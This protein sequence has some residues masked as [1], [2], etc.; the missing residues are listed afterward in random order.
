MSDHVATQE[1]GFLIPHPFI[2]SLPK[3]PISVSQ[4]PSTGSHISNTKCPVPHLIWAYN[5]MFL[6][7]TTQS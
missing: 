5:N 1:P 4:G 2:L 3:P 6:M 7:L